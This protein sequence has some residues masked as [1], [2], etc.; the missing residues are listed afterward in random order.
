MIEFRLSGGVANTNPAASTGGDMSAFGFDGELPSWASSPL[1][2]L[3][4]VASAGNGADDGLGPFAARLYVIRG[5]PG[6]AEIAFKPFG[7][8]GLLISSG[9]G[10]I[11][12]ASASGRVALNYASRVVVFDVN[13]PILPAEDT[14][15][16]LA[17][18]QTG[19]TLFPEITEADAAAGSTLFRCVYV[20]NA[21]DSMTSA[22]LTFSGFPGA[23]IMAIAFDPAGAGQTASAADPSLLEYGQSAEVTLGA[24]QAAALWLRRRARTY[25]ATRRDPDVCVLQAEVI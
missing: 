20:R 8:P 11:V 12:A 16:A 22:R 9:G 4:L 15:A 23:S 21:G 3:S 6:I 25:N 17:F 2:G 13:F 7:L 5:A 24:G 10:N 1:P 19:E 14:D 18:G